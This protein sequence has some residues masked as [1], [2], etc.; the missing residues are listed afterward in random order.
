MATRNICDFL[1]VNGDIVMRNGIIIGRGGPNDKKRLELATRNGWSIPNEQ[2]L[3]HPPERL[4][5]VAQLWQQQR[6][7]AKLRSMTAAYNCMGMVFGC[8]R[9]SIDPEHLERILKDDDFEK[10]DSVSNA[11]RGDVAVYRKGGEVQHVGIV[12]QVVPDVEKA[13]NKLLILSQWGS[14]G[15]W[16][17]PHDCV[18]EA[19]GQISEVWTDRRRI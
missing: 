13:T 8:R 12:I 15:E 18:P 4:K 3:E 6:P 1:G 19:Y 7:N 9:T 10:L 5:Y 14:D 17:H 2:A 11:E 16:I